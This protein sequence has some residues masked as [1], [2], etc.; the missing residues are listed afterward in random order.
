MNV[1]DEKVVDGLTL[2]TVTTKRGITINALHVKK[3]DPEIQAALG[4]S[5]SRDPSGLRERIKKVLGDDVMKKRIMDVFFK[6][7]GHNS[8]GDMGFMIMSIEGLSMKGAV[9]VVEHQLFNGQEASTRYINFED[10]GFL[11]VSE[12]VDQFSQKCFGLYQRL[13]ANLLTHFVS[14]GM[15]EKAAEPKAF[16]IAG[17]FLPISARTNVYWVGSIRTYI[18]K[19][20]ELTSLDQEDQEIG[21]AMEAV[22]DHVC[23]NSVRRVDADSLRDQLNQERNILTRE[24][25]LVKAGVSLSAFNLNGFKEFMSYSKSNILSSKALSVFG[26]I[27]VFSDIDFRSARDIHRHRIF[28]VNKILSYESC[29]VEE[30]YLNEIP[31]D[32]LREEISREVRA[33]IQEAEVL[34]GGEY[35]MPMAVK[36]SYA[37]SGPLNGWLYFLHLRSGKTVHPT[38]IS[39]AHKVASVLE[40]ELGLTGLCRSEAVDY[41]ARSEDANKV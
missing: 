33:I 28:P 8:I 10:M 30:F 35:G 24:K 21:M 16:D 26:N 11:P 27:N 2:S 25:G 17:A 7:Y 23:P 29:G 12:D 31:D 32:G 14:Q 22:L 34:D 15:E 9:N 37:M 6:K 39:F 1:V 40:R 36:F 19:I 38:V 3:F 41:A 18:D 5:L 20:R 4:A 13:K